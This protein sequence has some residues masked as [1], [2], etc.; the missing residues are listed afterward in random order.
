MIIDLMS[1]SLLK[2]T[3]KFSKEVR[4]LKYL[5]Y[6]QDPRIS[7]KEVIAH[8]DSL[9]F[10]LT[11]HSQKIYYLFIA[12]LHYFQIIICSPFLFHFREEADLLSRALGCR[13]M[14]TSVKEDINVNS[15]FRY[16]T[17]KCLAELRQQEEE[18]S[19]NGNGLPP[20]T[21]SKF[22]VRD[23]KSETDCLVRKRCKEVQ[24][25]DVLL[26]KQLCLNMTDNQQNY[27]IRSV[28]MLSF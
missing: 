18:Y 17:T 3:L 14:R 20:Y 5:I 27:C 16:L 4:I 25:K 21:I 28:K 2:L 10:S 22:A 7:Y 12:S 9:A 1:S 8:D 6:Q 26:R 23:A 13:L 24:Q 15:I 19:I 11:L